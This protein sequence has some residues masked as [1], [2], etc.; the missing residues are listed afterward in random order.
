MM[1][2]VESG[3]KDHEGPSLAHRFQRERQ[4]AIAPIHVVQQFA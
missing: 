3:A 1:D 4:G 2:A